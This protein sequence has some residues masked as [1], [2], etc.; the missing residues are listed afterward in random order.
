MTDGSLLLVHTV[1]TVSLA[2]GESEVCEKSFRVRVA[3]RAHTINGTGGNFY[4]NVQY[5]NDYPL[6]PAPCAGVR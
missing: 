2:E 4:R 1:Q 5:R 6:M 3:P